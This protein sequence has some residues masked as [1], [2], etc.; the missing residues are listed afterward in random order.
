MTGGENGTVAHLHNLHNTVL[1]TVQILKIL[2]VN[3][4]TN[5]DDNSSLNEF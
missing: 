1:R 2:M 3:Y 4:S 5:D